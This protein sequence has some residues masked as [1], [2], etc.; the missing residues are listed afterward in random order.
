MAL[1][2]SSQGTAVLRR[3]LRYVRPYSYV[4]V[5]AAIAMVI[6]ALVTAAV[7]LLLEDILD[8]FSERAEAELVAE[9]NVLESLRL[10]LLIVVAFALRG[11]MDVFTVYGLG[12]VGRSAVRDL[13]TELFRHFLCL[14]ASS[15]ITGE[16]IAVDGGFL[17]YGF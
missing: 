1:G 16:C 2:L 9:G 14:P 13:R 5:P 3:L 4:L 7:P 15:Y 17:R 12:W 11:V 10:P 6:Y 8:E